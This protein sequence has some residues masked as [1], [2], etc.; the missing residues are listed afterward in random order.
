VTGPESAVAREKNGFLEIVRS[1]KF[2]G[3]TPQWTLPEG[4]TQEAGDDRELLA[5]VNIPAEPPLEMT[6]TSLPMRGD[7][8][9]Y[10][11]MN[12]NRWRGQMGLRAMAADQPHAGG[13]LN[14]ETIEILLDNAITATLVNIAGQFR[15]GSMMPP[16]A[17]GG[18]AAP[19][20]ASGQPSPQ[21]Q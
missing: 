6:V 4:W 16:F 9:E 3:N 21:S 19:A 1:V 18:A 13:D 2:D 11:L 17:A 20:S 15:S 7:D 10:R 8:M 5:T 14:E 12:V